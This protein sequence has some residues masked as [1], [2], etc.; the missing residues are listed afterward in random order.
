MAPGVFV[1]SIVRSFVGSF[2]HFR[3]ARNDPSRP[4]AAP[5]QVNSGVLQYSALLKAARGGLM[6]PV[7]VP[8]EP[9]RH[10]ETATGLVGAV[11]SEVDAV[12]ALRGRLLARAL[13]VGRSPSSPPATSIRSGERKRCAPA[14]FDCF[15]RT[16]L[17]RP[18][19]VRSGEA[20]RVRTATVGHERERE[21]ESHPRLPHTR[22]AE[23]GQRK[24]RA[25]HAV[26]ACG[27][28]WRRGGYVGAVSPMSLRMCVRMCVCPTDADGAWER[29]KAVG[30]GLWAWGGTGRC[31]TCLAS[32]GHTD[33]KGSG[34]RP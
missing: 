2:V 1:S 9:A 19:G 25:A 31:P 16:E 5:T 10:A 7:P 11:P 4:G 12:A 27:G 22:A 32:G 8:Y 15:E 34:R 20:G 28:E 13:S 26:H 33:A 14:S 29:G 18:K 6:A 17:A 30:H 21:G 23:G 24:A 3:N